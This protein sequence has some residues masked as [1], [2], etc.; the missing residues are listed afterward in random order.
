M[1]GFP[2]YFWPNDYKLKFS[3]PPPWVFYFARMAHRTPGST[4]LHSLADFIK[5]TEK[6]ADGD[7]EGEVWKR[8][9]PELLSTCVPAWPVHVL[10]KLHASGIFTEASS[11]MHG[12][13][14]TQSLAPLPFLKDEGKAESSKLL[15]M[16]CSFWWPISILKLSRS[17]PRVGSLQQKTFL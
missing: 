12:Q 11:R 2:G 16:V 3:W 4:Y 1:S 10:S 14:L 8:G 5:V 6:Q 15:I 17:L 13:L 9:V 7:T